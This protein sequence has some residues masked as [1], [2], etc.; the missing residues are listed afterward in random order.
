MGKKVSR[1]SQKYYRMKGCSKKTCKNFFG[2]RADGDFDLAFT[3][4]T[5]PMAKNPFLAYNGKGGSCQSSN[6]N[7]GTPIPMN[8]NSLNK[9]IPNTGPPVGIPTSFSNQAG[10]QIGGNCGCGLP[11]MTGG[12]IKKGGS[13]GSLCAPGY[14]VGG[15]HRIGCK[16][17]SCKTIQSGGNPGKL[18]PNGTTGNAW[19]PKISDW[20]GVDG[21]QGGRDFFKLNTFPTDVQT[22]T[23]YAGANPPFSIGG[24]KSKKSKKY[25]RK[26]RGGATSN[27]LSQ[28]L[29]NIGRSSQFNLGSAY[30]ALAGYKAPVNPLPWKNQLPNTPSLS[31]IKAASI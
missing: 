9:S 27:L 17:S 2:G 3:G 18:Y 20:P 24:K 31:T 22:A 14:M 1:K 21:V 15:N 7:P 10:P 12:N 30:N 8:T 13:C 5:I 28:D 11:S 4:K 6:L 23:I 16:C 29:I 25:S 26:Q 19:T